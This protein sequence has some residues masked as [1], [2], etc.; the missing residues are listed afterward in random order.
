VSFSARELARHIKADIVGDNDTELTHVVDLEHGNEGGLSFAASPKYIDQ[1]KRSNSSAVIVTPELLPHCHSLAL[2]SSDPYLSFA[3]AA[4]L[5]HPVKSF[6]AGIHPSAFIDDACDIGENVYVG[7]NVVIDAECKIGD[8]SYIGA[9]CVI[10]APS[11]IGKNARFIS[12]VTITGE[13]IIGDRVILHPGVVIGSD[14]FGLANDQ[15]VWQKIPQLGK[16]I[17]GN[18]VE[19]GANTTVDRGAL[20]DTIIEDGVKLDNQIQVAHNVKIGA[21]TAVAGCA[22]IAGSATI[23]KHCAIGGGAG[24]QGHIEITDGVQVTGMTKVSQSIGT[25]G[26]YTSGTAAQD[27]KK[28]MRNAMRFKELDEVVRR[29]Q[30]LEK[31]ID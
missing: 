10:T 1:L 8:N 29:L 13:S 7:P 25:P 15:G 4:Q 22:G 20:L 18:D 5:L 26:V 3:L 21:H 31:K 27:N 16:V 24:I 11:K 30:R 14:G 19:I 2:V 23:G 9:A 28:W 17:I 12:G 6:H